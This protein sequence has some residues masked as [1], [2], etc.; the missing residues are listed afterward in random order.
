MKKLELVDGLYA[1]VRLSDGKIDLRE[2]LVENKLIESHSIHNILKL[3]RFKKDVEEFQPEGVEIEKGK[4]TEQGRE[5]N[6]YWVNEMLLLSTASE[7]SPKI[8]YSFYKYFLENFKVGE[9]LLP[10]SFSSES[11]KESDDYLYLIIN[12][13]KNLV[14]IGRSYNVER[15][16]KELYRTENDHCGLEVLFKLPCQGH[17]ELETHVK[18]KEFRVKGEWFNYDESII[19]FF[20]DTLEDL[21]EDL[22]KPKGLPF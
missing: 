12:K 17:T 5:P 13:R 19:K 2:F 16:V 10:G 11:G 14:K 8:K 15:R 4:N 1:N 3:D 7:L 20:E 9:D 18:F 6:K 22:K 21:S